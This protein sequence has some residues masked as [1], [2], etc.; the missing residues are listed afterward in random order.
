LAKSENFL[1]A[2]K[3]AIEPLSKIE[4]RRRQPSI[5]FIA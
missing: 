1:E 4:S 3:K 2:K 5:D